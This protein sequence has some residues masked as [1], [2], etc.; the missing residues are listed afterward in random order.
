MVRRP[1]GSHC[2]RPTDDDRLL[3]WEASSLKA[4]SCLLPSI[5]LF[6]CGAMSLGSHLRS[7]VCAVLPS[8]ITLIPAVILPDSE[9]LHRHVSGIAVLPSC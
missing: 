9:L 7:C 2:Q 3:H 8:D 1:F 6:A 5:Q 4:T